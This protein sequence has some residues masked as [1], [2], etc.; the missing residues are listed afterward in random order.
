[1]STWTTR[2]STK[3]LS[4]KYRGHLAQMPQRETAAEGASVEVAQR[5]TP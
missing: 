5:I 2:L 3:R 4:E 1:M